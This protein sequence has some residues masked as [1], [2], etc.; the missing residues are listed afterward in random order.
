MKDVSYV[1]GIEI[2]R[3]RNKRLLSLSQRNYITKILKKFEMSSCSTNEVSIVKGD[4][5]NKFQYP[6]KEIERNQMKNISYASAVD[7]LMYV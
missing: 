2:H 4:K 7:S 3:D 1:L 6:R 5:F